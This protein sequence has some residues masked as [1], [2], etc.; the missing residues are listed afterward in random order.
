MIKIQ[1]DNIENNKTKTIEIKKLDDIY[2]PSKEQYEVPNQTHTNILTKMDVNLRVLIPYKN[3]EDF[4]YQY[5]NDELFSN[6]TNFNNDI[7][8]KKFKQVF[9]NIQELGIYNAMK[10]YL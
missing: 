2:T 9:R 3:G 1:C 7:K 5:S 10:K 6:L 8:G 4:I